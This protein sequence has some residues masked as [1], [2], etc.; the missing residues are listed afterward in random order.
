[1]PDEQFET[2]EEFLKLSEPPPEEEERRDTLVR[3]A[4]AAAADALRAE[5]VEIEMLREDLKREAVNLMVNVLEMSYD[6]ATNVTWIPFN[7]DKARE[8]RFR[9]EGLLFRVDY[10]GDPA[11]T[12]ARIAFMRQDVTPNIFDSL[13]ALGR[14]LG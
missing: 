5:K 7:N 10:Q 3:R 14:L 6:E 9:V 4:R 13:T 1:M 12:E 8:V 2:V 11:T